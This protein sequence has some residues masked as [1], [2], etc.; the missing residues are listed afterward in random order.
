MEEIAKELANLVDM[1]NW[2]WWLA[3]AIAALK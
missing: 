1:L 2:F 3:L